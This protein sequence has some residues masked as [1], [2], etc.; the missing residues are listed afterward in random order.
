[1]RMRVLILLAVSFFFVLCG[2]KKEQKGIVISNPQAL[3]HLRIGQQY[4][5]QDQFDAAIGELR[6]AVKLDS[7]LA[8]AW[9]RLGFV[10]A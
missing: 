4:I 9:D 2:Q 8:E 10:L 7:T 1:M 5:E 3:N 6:A